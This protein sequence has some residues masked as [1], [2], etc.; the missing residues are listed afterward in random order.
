MLLLLK[1]ACV[2]DDEDVKYLQYAIKG[3]SKKSSS[4]FSMT[5][6]TGSTNGHFGVASHGGDVM[7]N[8][9]ELWYLFM[10]ALKDLILGKMILPLTIRKL[11]F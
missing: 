6:L 7:W 4:S 9:K 8:W 5:G 1:N 10:F 2:G 3:I 11:F